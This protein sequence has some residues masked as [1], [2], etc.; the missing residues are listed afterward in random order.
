MSDAIDPD[1]LT[2]TAAVCRPIDGGA[3][4]LRQFTADVTYVGEYDDEAIGGVMGW[5]GWQILDDDVHD[6]ADAISGDAETLGQAAEQIIEAYPENYIDTVLLIDRMHIDPK[7][8]GHRLSGAIIIDLM[9]LFRL[10]RE[11]TA[12]V[13][14]PEPQRPEGGPFPYGSER[15]QAMARLEA[16]YEE[17]GLERWKDTVVWWLPL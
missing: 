15:N 13:L 12:V 10:D 6:A 11:R 14:Q 4:V 8:R 1:L 16:A 17:S 3:D 7:W 9:A 2:T 5:I